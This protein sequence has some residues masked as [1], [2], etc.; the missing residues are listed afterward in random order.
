MSID[1]ELTAAAPLERQIEHIPTAFAITSGDRHTL[2]YAN[3]VF[4]DLI[5]PNGRILLGLPIA[6]A[7]PTRNT[8]ELTALLDRSLRA[9]VVSR[10]VHLASLDDGVQPLS[11]TI[12]PDLQIDEKSAH[13]VIELRARK[14]APLTSRL[15]REIAERLLMSALRE[16]DAAVKAHEAHERANFLAAE[17]RRLGESL[18]E[19]ATLES[20]RA[21]VLPTLGAWCIVDT[22]SPD[23]T[24]LTQTIPHSDP[25]KQSIIAELEDRW[26]LSHGDE[27]GLHEAMRSGLPWVITNS[28]GPLHERAADVLK[29]DGERRALGVGPLLTVPLIIREALIGSLTFV[30]GPR[31]RSFRSEEIELAREL[32]SRSATALDRAH[33]F[34]EAVTLKVR[35]EAA[36]NAKTAFLGMMSHELRTPLNA[37]GGYVDIIDLELHGPVTQEQHHDL[38]RIRSSQQYLT[39][40]VADLL[41][42]TKVTSGLAVYDDNDILM[43]DVV[44][45]SLV[46]LEPLFAKK[47]LTPR[48]VVNDER[49]VALGDRE[50]VIQ[51]VVNLLTNGAKFTQPGGRL[52]ISCEATPD[53]VFLRVT[54]N[55][56][57]I[58]SDKQEAIFEPF[59]QVREDSV[60][61]E[62]GIG[63]GLAISRTLA[64]GMHGELTVE[65]ALGMGSCFTLA[66]PRE[67]RNRR[68]TFEPLASDTAS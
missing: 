17:S 56:I 35:A 39:R 25:V 61:S 50:K 6:D 20:I 68:G 32:A 31:D 36:S 64:R 63:L 29:D 11:C 13:L 54:D 59:V 55:G 33:A 40:L 49:I 41:S 66:L 60:A 23:G 65:S 18:D 27:L 34:G 53:R 1:A 42:L 9:G 16:H 3:A 62:G 8:T 57:G 48:V 10:D 67:R 22:F 44:D 45:T 7:L 4:R 37:I 15:Q 38:N 52:V 51:I 2:V 43:Q 28:R 24:R 46:L 14:E 19:A 58:P 47:S 5:A 12:W 21:I 30:G 26:D